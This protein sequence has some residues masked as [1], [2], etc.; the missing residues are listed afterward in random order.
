MGKGKEREWK[1]TEQKGRE[2][3]R[4]K[5]N[6]WERR[7]KMRDGKHCIRTALR[8]GSALTHF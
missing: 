3:E 5:G 1:E 2:W 8:V 6:R 4:R 7:K